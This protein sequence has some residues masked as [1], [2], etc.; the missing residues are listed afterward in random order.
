MA[1]STDAVWRHVNR[2]TFAVISWVTPAGEPRSAGVVYRAEG[3]R[4]YVGIDA[5][6][7]KDRH[8]TASG[9]VSVTVLVR[10]GGLLS[11]FAQIPPA[12]ITFRGAAVVHPE[13]ALPTLPKVVE[14][15]LPPGKEPRA[16]R[17]I[18][19]RPEG[20]FV[21]YGIGVALPTMLK[22]DEASGRAPV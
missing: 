2:K 21:T 9:R 5:D 1:V 12:T 18:E 11:L 3:R 14:K 10:R 8:I 13:D 17:I 20:D 15:L 16:F 4:V 19:I 7:W 22:P 6:S